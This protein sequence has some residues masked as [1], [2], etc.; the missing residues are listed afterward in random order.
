VQVGIEAFSRAQLRGTTLRLFINSHFI[1]E[2]VAYNIVIKEGNSQHE[3]VPPLYSF[4]LIISVIGGLFKSKL[5]F[6]PDLTSS[7]GIDISH[8]FPCKIPKPPVD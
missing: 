6:E 3:I 8:A 4:F 1:F 7:S 2:A 5:T